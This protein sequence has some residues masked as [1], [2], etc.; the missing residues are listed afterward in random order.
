MEQITI[1]GKTFNVP[2]RYEE[3]H[4]LTAGEA[5]A[6]NQTYHENIRNNLAKKV[7]ELDDAGTFD[8]NSMQAT[9][10]QYAES[11]QFG[12]RAAGAGVSRDPVMSE[13]MRIAK[14]QLGELLKKSGKKASDYTSETITNAAKALLAKSSDIMELAKQRVAEQQSLAQADLGDILSGLA[15]KPAEQPQAEA[16]Q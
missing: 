6:L 10:D 12:I 14:K 2:L 7:K 4:E 13:A 16:A 8:Q 9:V 3:G 11:Y 15:E 5:S 1:A